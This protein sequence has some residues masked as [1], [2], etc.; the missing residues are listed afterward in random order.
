[1]PIRVRDLAHE[2]ATLLI[3]C[4]QCGSVALY[5][6]ELLEKRFGADGLISD[7]MRRFR[8]H[9]DGMIPDGVIVLDSSEASA[10]ALARPG[11]SIHQPMVKWID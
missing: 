6:P 4:R 2:R 7:L 11:V 9:R 3:R 10:E 1:M 5:F 8:C